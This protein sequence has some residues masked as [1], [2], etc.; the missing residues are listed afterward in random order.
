[1]SFWS[2]AAAFLFAAFVLLDAV[3]LFPRQAGASLRRNALGYSFLVM[4]NTTK[5]VFIVLYPPLLGLLSMH[6]EDG[7]FIETVLM[8]HVLGAASLLIVYVLR[9]RVFIFFTVAIGQYSKGKNLP[10]AFWMALVLAIRGQARIAHVAIPLRKVSRSI[11]IPALII[12][13]FYSSAGFITNILAQAFQSHAPFIL[14][15]IGVV[16]SFGTLVLSFVLDPK[17]SKIFEKGDPEKI[18]IPSLFFAQFFNIIFVS[19][20]AL[21]SLIY[22]LS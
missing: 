2:L 19:P 14:Q 15:L 9:D 5:R 8:A 13:F 7:I 16:N 12:F 6:E 4:I 1:M 11:A 22:I 3:S 17:I 21:L 10:K 18:V 20:I